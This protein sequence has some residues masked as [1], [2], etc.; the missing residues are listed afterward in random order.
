MGSLLTRVLFRDFGALP[1]LLEVVGFGRR[2]RWENCGGSSCVRAIWFRS[3]TRWCAEYGSRASRRAGGRS[4]RVLAP[5]FDAAFAALDEGGC[6]AP[7]P[8]RQADARSTKRDRARRRRAASR[9]GRY[10]EI[11]ITGSVG[12]GGGDAPVDT[13]DTHGLPPGY[14]LRESTRNQ[15]PETRTPKPGRRRMPTTTDRGSPALRGPG[16][17]CEHVAPAGSVTRSAVL[18]R[19][20]GS[21]RC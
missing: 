20:R 13:T 5:S 16:T 10:V 2:T 6:E 17:T 19:A 8:R 18:P 4:V 1:V 9:S 14:E 7:V 15:D 21:V 11:D 3:S 12:A